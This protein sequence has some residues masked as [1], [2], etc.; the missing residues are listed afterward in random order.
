MLAQH[1]FSSQSGTAT[2]AGPNL[3]L[4]VRELG[5]RASELSGPVIVSVILSASVCQVN[6]LGKGGSLLVDETRE[7][8]VENSL[9]RVEPKGLAGY[10][11]PVVTHIPTLPVCHFKK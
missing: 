4:D 9:C 11:F 5:L 1:H 3:T 2:R 10:V 7:V 8:Q 6:F